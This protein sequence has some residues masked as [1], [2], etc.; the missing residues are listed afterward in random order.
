MQRVAYGGYF[1][2]AVVLHVFGQEVGL[3]RIFQ[4]NFFAIKLRV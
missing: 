1:G 3:S 2:Y 4:K